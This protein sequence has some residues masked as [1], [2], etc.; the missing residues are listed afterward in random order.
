M[1]IAEGKLGKV[2]NALV[3]R[4]LSRNLSEK[5]ANRVKLS[6]A[7][8]DDGTLVV[9]GGGWNLPPGFPNY[10]GTWNQFTGAGGA[11]ILDD[12]SHDSWLNRVADRIWG[13]DCVISAVYSTDQPGQLVA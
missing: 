9:V 7:A 3:S 10:C 11:L 8:M 5:I 12:T 6:P 1:S 2:V 4:H 13:A